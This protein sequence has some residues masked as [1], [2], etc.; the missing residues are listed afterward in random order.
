MDQF[1]LPKISIITVCLNS[2]KHLERTIASVLS[3]AYQFTEYIIV[4]G[5]ST[6]RTLAIIDRYREHIDTLVSE[7]D[8]GIYDAQNKAIKLATGDIICILN[9]DDRFYNEHVL[10]RIVNCF[11]QEDVDFVYGDILFS[12][13]SQDSEVCAVKFPERLSKFYFL[14]GPLGHPS[15]FFRKRCFVKV[16]YYDTRYKISADYEWYLRALFK[17]GLRS[18]HLKEFIAIFQ[19]GGT[20][21][22]KDLRRQETNAVLKQYFKPLELLAGKTINF[23]LYGDI[24]RFLGR[25]ILRRKGYQYLRS[26]SR[27]SNSKRYLRKGAKP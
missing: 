13:D 3:Q 2:E 23:F 14:R 26:I 4:D 17:K 24:L 15:T 6:D 8:N 5:G 7:P 25:V 12:S 21:D 20:S 19:A 27:R 9:S 22:E 1:S 11:A 18:A 16:G 10:E